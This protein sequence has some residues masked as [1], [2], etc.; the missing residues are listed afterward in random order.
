MLA[1]KDEEFLS[2]VETLLSGMCFPCHVVPSGES[3]FMSEA[4]SVLKEDARNQV[5]EK[6]GDR[7]DPYT[8]RMNA[9]RLPTDREF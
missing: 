7:Y 9:G 2:Y 6:H 5:L 3:W 4:L 8:A 1:P